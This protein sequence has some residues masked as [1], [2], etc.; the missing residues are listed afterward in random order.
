MNPINPMQLLQLKSSWE[1][2]KMRHPKFPP[3]LSSVANGAI[4][5]G[6]VIEIS[7][8]TADGRT[9]HSNLKVSNEDMELMEQIKNLTNN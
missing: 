2:F 6:S 9:I 4:T 1:L 7:I 3:F 5:E 8:T